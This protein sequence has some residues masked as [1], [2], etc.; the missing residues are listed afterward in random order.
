[1]LQA[2]KGRLE[3]SEVSVSKPLPLLI[4]ESS[5]MPH[6]GINLHFCGYESSELREEEEEDEEAAAD[7][8]WKKRH[9]EHNKGGGP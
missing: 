2:W 9:R 8:D 1:M 4:G 3:G 6:G 7:R 5:G